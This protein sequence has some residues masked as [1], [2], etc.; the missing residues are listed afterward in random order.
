MS[1][2]RGYR[3]LRESAAWLDLSARGKIRVRG[4]DRARLLHAMTTNHIQELTPGRGCYAFFLNA[5][6]RILGDVNVLTFPGHFLLDTE[7]ETKNTLYAHL[8]KYIIADDVTLE[9][10]T[11]GLATLSIEGPKAGDV[12]AVLGAPAPAKPYSHADWGARIVARIDS[13]GAGG[14]AIFGPASEKQDLA[15]ALE[16]AGAVPAD[17]EAERTVRLE[18]GKPRYGEEITDANLPQETQQMHAIH[19]NK[20]C[21][22]GQEIVERI[23]SR[24]HVNRLL[25]RLELDCAEPPAAGSS[26]L[27]EGKEVGEIKSAV[28]SPA[29]GTVVAMAYVRAEFAAE[30]TGFT[31]EP[32]RT[33]S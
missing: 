20:G 25:V 27:R 22:L 18:H 24:G 10:A 13:T 1:E 28:L 16:G 9:D 30:R 4:E 12:L 3:E 29:L 17:P 31:A 5:Q 33:Q 32:R 23:R 11:A 15:R 7:P 21:Y 26:L 8:D 19:F 2:P 14:F 6:G